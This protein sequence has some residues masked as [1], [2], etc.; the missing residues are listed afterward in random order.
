MHFLR[1]KNKNLNLFKIV[2]KIERV[3]LVVLGEKYIKELKYHFNKSKS[4]LK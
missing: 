2:I 4:L 1:I 3:E